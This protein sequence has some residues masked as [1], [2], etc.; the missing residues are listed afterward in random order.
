MLEPATGSVLGHVSDCTIEDFNTAIEAASIAQVKYFEETTAAQR[1][2]FLRSWYDAI[3]ANAKDRK[4]TRN[5]H[6]G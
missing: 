5:S 2:A 4:S 1:G 6:L 3:I